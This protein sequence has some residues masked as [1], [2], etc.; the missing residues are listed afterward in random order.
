M[1]S[2]YITKEGEKIK[3]EKTQQNQTKQFNKKQVLFVLKVL[4][5]WKHGLEK[6]S[7]YIRTDSEAQTALISQSHQCPDPTTISNC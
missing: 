6:P 7:C 4:T 5:A 1:R 2:W 3:R